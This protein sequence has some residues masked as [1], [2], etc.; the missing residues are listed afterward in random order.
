MATLKSRIRWK[1]WAPDLGENRTLPEGPALYLEL[2]TDLTAQQLD[3]VGERL[4]AKGEPV[5]TREELVAGMRARFGEALGPYV[6]VHGGPHTVDGQPLATLDD[7]LALVTQSAGCGASQLRELHAALVAFNSVTGP[8][9][10]F[11]LPRSGGVRTTGARSNDA[12]DSPT[13][14]H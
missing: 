10:L 13:D 14:S 2:A 5:R 1:K 11:S 7:Y 12:A 4:T 6:R 3:E 8:D 9:E